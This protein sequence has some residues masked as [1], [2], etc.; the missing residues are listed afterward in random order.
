MTRQITVVVK[1]GDGELTD[2][3]FIVYHLSEYLYNGV[4]ALAVR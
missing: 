1:K 2:T 4:P 3:G